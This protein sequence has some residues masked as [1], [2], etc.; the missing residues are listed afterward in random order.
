MKK[1]YNKLVRDNIPAIIR[2][3]KKKARYRVLDQ[4]EYKQ[5]LKAKLVEEATE[6]L[7]AET[8]D[9]MI[10][11]LADI[12]QVLETLLFINDISK[13]DIAIRQADKWREKGGFDLR[14]YL[15]SVED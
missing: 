9:E 10:E 14:Y 15:E 2:K 11:E 8:L 1:I 5:A 3:S 6:L 12:K 4:N 7:N 13:N